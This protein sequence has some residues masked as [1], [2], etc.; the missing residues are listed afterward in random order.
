MTI[1]A[2]PNRRP[3]IV[4]DRTGSVVDVL[5]Q[6][7]KGFTKSLEHG[8]LWV[9]HPETDRLLPDGRRI[10]RITDRGR[11]YQAE[12]GPTTERSNERRAPARPS[13]GEEHRNAG[14]G[15]PAASAATGPSGPA[16]VTAADASS[17]AHLG[18]VLTRLA[19]VIADRRVAMPEG[20]YT[21]HLFASGAAKIRKKAGEEAV[22][23]LLAAGHDELVH[24][25][26]DLLY[27][28]LVLLEQ[29]Q[30]GLPEIAAELARRE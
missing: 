1:P 21:T 13:D 3:L 9:L 6:D 15:A 29:E 24:E 26:A 30:I 18:A 25:T 8:T 20:S 4:V 23:L 11:W 17:P 27:H 7:A 19:A 10:T 12:L 14:S 5:F 22:E 2:G 28:M 16:A